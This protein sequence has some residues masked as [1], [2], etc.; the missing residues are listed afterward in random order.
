MTQ[1]IVHV[2]RTLRAPKDIVRNSTNLLSND[3]CFLEEFY[4]PQPSTRGGDSLLQYALCTHENM[5]LY[6]MNNRLFITI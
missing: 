1:Y 4:N 2:N 6:R 5:I 3:T